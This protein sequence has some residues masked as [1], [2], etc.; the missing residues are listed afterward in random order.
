[1]GEVYRDRRKTEPRRRWLDDVQN[2]TGLSLQE[3]EKAARDHFKWKQGVMEI[4][5]GHS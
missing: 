5:R 1:M 3:A 4:T 2:I